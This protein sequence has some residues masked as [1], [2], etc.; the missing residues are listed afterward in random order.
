[1][2]CIILSLRDYVTCGLLF[3][4]YDFSTLSHPFVRVSQSPAPIAHNGQT[5]YNAKFL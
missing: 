1:M 3:C 5:Q 2:V 4:T